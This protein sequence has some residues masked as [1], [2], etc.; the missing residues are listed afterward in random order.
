MAFYGPPSASPADNHDGTVEGPITQA[1][2]DHVRA[3]RL[4]RVGAAGS[5]K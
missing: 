1:V 4:R 5:S 3:E 2:I